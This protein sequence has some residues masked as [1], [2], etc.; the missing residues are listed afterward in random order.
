MD[1]DIFRRGKGILDF[2]FAR[3]RVWGLGS[4]IKNGYF[5]MKI[6]FNFHLGGGGAPDPPTRS[7]QETVIIM[8]LMKLKCTETIGL[9]SLL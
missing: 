4:F 3:G 5:T 9:C 2:F 6:V 1:L 8:N 7:A